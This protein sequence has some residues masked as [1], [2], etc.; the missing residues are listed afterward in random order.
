M[1]HVN[2]KKKVNSK[3][4]FIRC[5]DLNSLIQTNRVASAINF[6]QFSFFLNSE[7]IGTVM[8]VPNGLPASSIK[9][10]LFVS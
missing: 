4:L 10:Q 1:Y 9:T 8:R 6:A 7:G 3:N 2:R 5:I